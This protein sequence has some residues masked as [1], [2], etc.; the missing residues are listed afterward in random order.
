[1]QHPGALYS[2][3]DAGSDSSDIRIEAAGVLTLFSL[4]RSRSGAGVER[5]NYDNEG[6]ACFTGPECQWLIRPKCS[7]DDE[8]AERAAS[9]HVIKSMMLAFAPVCMFPGCLFSPF[10]TLLLFL[11]NRIK[12]VFILRRV[13]D[14][15][16]SRC[17]TRGHYDELLPLPSPKSYT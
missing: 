5:G 8:A 9:E 1:M 12:S 13:I 15:N 7:E 2:D 14:P 6:T 3:P 4:I 16:R 10:T 11:T 17:Q